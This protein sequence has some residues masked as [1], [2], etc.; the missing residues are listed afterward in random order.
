MAVFCAASA[1]PKRC[2]AIENAIEQ[3]SSPTEF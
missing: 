3:L 2:A 1:T